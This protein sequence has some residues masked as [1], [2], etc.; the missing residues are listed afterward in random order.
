MRRAT[1]DEVHPHRPRRV[2]PQLLQLQTLLAHLQGK[3]AVSH[4]QR[5]A[6]ALGPLLGLGLKG[7]AQGL[8]MDAAGRRLLN[9]GKTRSKN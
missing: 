5:Q 8:D 1:L 7:R 2:R 9:H 3:L 6:Q 4:L